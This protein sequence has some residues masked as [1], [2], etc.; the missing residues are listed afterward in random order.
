MAIEDRVTRPGTPERWSR[1]LTYKP[2]ADG[3]VQSVCDDGFEDS[4]LVHD[5]AWSLIHRNA[6]DA[7]NDAKA[8]RRS[9]LH[10]HMTANLLNPDMLAQLVGMWRWRVRRHL[11]P[12]V[13]AG[14]S[15]ALL[16]KYAWALRLTVE[17][18]TSL[19]AQPP[20]QHAAVGTVEETP[21]N[22]P[23]SGTGG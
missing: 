2:D 14:L 23:S 1:I 10:Y 18:L 17:E 3:A 6:L 21:D 13:F 9:T 19:P 8:G 16:Q 5:V 11:R 15:S 22:P 20:P 4:N 7:W 12:D